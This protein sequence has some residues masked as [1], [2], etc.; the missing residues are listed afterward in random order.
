[1]ILLASQ[2]PQRTELL[3][4]AGLAHVV[5]ATAEDDEVANTL[6]AQALAVER[7]RHKAINAQWQEHVGVLSA[8]SAAVIAADTVV[9]LQGK[10]VGKPRDREHAKRILASLAGTQ[11][12]VITAHCCWLPEH[13]GQAA[14]EA[15]AIAM[16]QITMLPM[17]M[18]EIEAYVA[19]GESDGRAGAYALQAEGDRYVADITGER[20]TVIGLNVAIV[21]KLYREVT[22]NAAEDV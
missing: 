7:A 13:N 5:I 19:S 17:S 4:Q 16:A 22:G 2:S 18:D 3:Q 14:C 15:V 6:P 21:R 11:H 20:D 9:A 10:D 12:T 8:G 1:M